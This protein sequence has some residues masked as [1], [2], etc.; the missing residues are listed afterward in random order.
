MYYARA[1]KQRTTTFLPG[2][3]QQ[4]QQQRPRPLPP[5]G[6]PAATSAPG[7]PRTFRRLTPAKQVEQRRQGLYFNCDEP[8]VR[9]HV[10]KQLFYLETDDYID[11]MPADTAAAHL[12]APAD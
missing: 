11:D 1:Y 3:L 10:C 6:Q 12:E 8:F 9:C 5:L 7:Q 2:L 4:Q